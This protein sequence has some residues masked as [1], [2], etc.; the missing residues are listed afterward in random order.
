MLHVFHIEIA[1]TMVN[2]VFVV[3]WLAG[4]PVAGPGDLG[5]A[6]AG[7]PSEIAARATLSSPRGRRHVGAM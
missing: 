4:G 5:R 3:G 2:C 7:L 6:G 1:V